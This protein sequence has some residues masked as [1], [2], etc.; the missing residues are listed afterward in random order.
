MNERI[1]EL[2]RK[3]G[4]S[5]LYEYDGYDGHAGVANFDDIEKFAELMMVDLINR[6][7]DIQ[8]ANKCVYTTFDK[9]IA[10]CVKNEIIKLIETTYNV[11]VPYVNA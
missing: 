4:I 7:N 1:K 3:A 11:K 5:I 10:D 8:T 9:S 2:A 6:I